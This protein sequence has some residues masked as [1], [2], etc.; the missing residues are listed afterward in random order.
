M[1]AAVFDGQPGTYPIL[2]LAALPQPFASL[3]VSVCVC[4][5]TWRRSELLVLQISVCSG[6]QGHAVKLPAD[7][8]A[9]PLKCC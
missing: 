5:G 4:R 1:R 6:A 3:G 2:Q 9:H 8:H 7:T